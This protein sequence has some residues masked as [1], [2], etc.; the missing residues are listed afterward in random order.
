MR[1][2]KFQALPQQKVASD[3]YKDTKVSIA[4]IDKE[5]VTCLVY[6]KFSLFRQTLCKAF[7]LEYLK[8]FNE[9]FGRQMQLLLFIFH[10]HL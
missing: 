4:L 5:S 8:V 3:I 9:R 1:S 10:G 7:N 6:V 2:F